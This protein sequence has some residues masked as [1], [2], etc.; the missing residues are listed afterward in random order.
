[1]QNQNVIIEEIKPLKYCY[2]F[3]LILYALLYVLHYILS[4][5]LY[6]L[7]DIYIKL[8]KFITY[9]GI[10]FYL[11]PIIPIIFI[12][13][14]Y[15]ILKIFSI[16]KILT[17]IFFI[18]SILSGILASIILWINT[19]YSKTFCKECPLSYTLSNLNKEF[20]EYYGITFINN[21][22][23]KKCQMKRCLLYN[24]NINEKYPYTYLCNYN[25]NSENKNKEYKRKLQNGTVIFSDKEFMCNELSSSYQYITFNS[26][27][28]YDYL[29]LCF[30][31]TKFYICKR[32]TVPKIYYHLKDDEICPE[33]IYLLLLY[34][35]SSL[36]ILT[37]IIIS[38]IPWF[39]EYISYKRLIFLLNS[40]NQNSSGSVSTK[41]NTLNSN[42]QE[43]FKKEETLMIVM[44]KNQS[45]EKDQN[46][47]HNKQNSEEEIV[48]GRIQIHKN[49]EN[50]N[51]E[52]KIKS[53]NQKYLISER[54]EK[55]SVNNEDHKNIQIT[56][57][58]LED[59]E[60][61]KKNNLI[62]INNL[63]Q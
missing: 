50:K 25:L 23:R 63:N 56:K 28:Y 30:S 22:I 2:I 9:F 53:R 37:D 62:I 8:F 39:I 41:K 36:V 15:F 7:N 5:R 40:N 16:F 47:S 58:N 14:K 38:F 13:I 3:H 24:E 44:S 35:I 19:I 32:F 11:I 10:I 45:K 54:S 18:L 61:K 48:L 12:F 51:N 52:S 6:W 21:K 49:I 42:N 26:N 55:N 57:K 1:M 17:L 31:L 4:I 43:S 59:E 20:K 46:N 60:D 27:E 29:D 34:L 33:D